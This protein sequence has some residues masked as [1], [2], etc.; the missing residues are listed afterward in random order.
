MPVLE[1]VRDDPPRSIQVRGHQVWAGTR[2]EERIA[3]LIHAVGEQLCARERGY[4]RRAAVIAAACFGLFAAYQ[5]LILSYG[6]TP[7]GAACLIAGALAPTAGTIALEGEQIQGSKPHAVA[8]KGIYLLA[9]RGA[10]P[11]A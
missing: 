10:E 3:L 2:A 1:D 6:F 9:A 7:P 8:A 5:A 4:G 11:S